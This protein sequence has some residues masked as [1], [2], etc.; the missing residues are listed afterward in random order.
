MS[1]LFKA[2][3][4]FLLL[5]ALVG[6]ALWTRSRPNVAQGHPERLRLPRLTVYIGGGLL[7][8]GFVLALGSFTSRYN[9]ELLPMRI[10]GGVTA[11]AGVIV[12]LMYRTWY[13]EPKADAIRFRTALG[14]ERTI[15]YRDIA[16]CR[17]DESGRRPRVSI[18]SRSGARLS[19]NPA[20]YPV[21]ALLAA[22]VFHERHGRWPEPGEAPVRRRR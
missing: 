5:L 19:L 12:L 10:L 18:R 6:V 20:M 11:L 16:S 2:V 21:P 3:L 7:V 17:L 15:A 13:V 1:F 14:R 8:A 22:I 4:V 9:A